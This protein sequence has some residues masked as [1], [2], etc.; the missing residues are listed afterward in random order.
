MLTIFFA[1]G[2]AFEVPVAVVLM[3]W[4]GFTSPGR[5]KQF[6][7]YALIIA[8]VV[9]FLLAPPDV[10]S[11][12]LLAVPIYLLFELGVIMARFMVPGSREVD[13]QR[14]AGDRA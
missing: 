7:P 9:G 12:T 11:M 4:M 6:R 13:A 3:V 14:E 10:V 1:F 2:V 8:F 5:L